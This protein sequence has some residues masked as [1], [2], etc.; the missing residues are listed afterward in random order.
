MYTSDKNPK[1]A[2]IQLQQQFYIMTKWFEK[3]PVRSLSSEDSGSNV[4]QEIK[5]N[6]VQIQNPKSLHQMVTKSQT[7]ERELWLQIQLQ[8]PLT[9]IFTQSYIIKV[10]LY[11]VLNKNSSTP[12]KTNL[13]SALFFPTRT[14]SRNFLSHQQ[15]GDA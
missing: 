8:L 4:Q 6:F 5:P 9:E 12:M 7:P 1:Q 15:T 14:R 11:P 2:I 13:I 3:S 10:M